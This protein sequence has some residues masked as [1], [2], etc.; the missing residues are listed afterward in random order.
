LEQGVQ[1]QQLAP[2]LL[3]QVGD[4]QR[5]LEQ[6]GVSEQLQ[7]F[8][9]AQQAPFAGLFELASILQGG[10]LGTVGSQTVGGGPSSTA[11]GITGALGGA[12]TAAGIGGLFGDS[13]FP[14]IGGFDQSGNA[15]GIGL[16]ALLGAIGGTA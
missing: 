8:Q 2:S 12:S 11:L 13:G 10:N 9:M 5:A 4:T 14:S 3:G 6:E 1:F 7:R 16:G 15:L